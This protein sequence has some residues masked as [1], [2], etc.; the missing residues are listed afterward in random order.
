MT[1]ETE[2]KETWYL[3][4]DRKTDKVSR[5]DFIH[6]IRSLGRKHTEQ[7]ITDITKHMSDPVTLSEFLE[8]MRKPYT[9]PTEDDLLTAL[10]AFDGNNSGYLRQ[11]ELVSLLTTLGEKMSEEEVQLV[12]KDV[13][14]DHEGRINIEEF[15]RYL[16]TPVPSLT[17][18]IEELKKQLGTK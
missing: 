12:M 6:I 18:N 1:T 15:A 7:E 5:A 13:K 2:W 11:S 10:R 3:F 8:Y 9:G 14:T 17:P 16:C 4:D